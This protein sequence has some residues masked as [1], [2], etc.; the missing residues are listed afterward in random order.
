MVPG[1][2]DLPRGTSSWSNRTRQQ[3]Q[4]CLVSVR[5]MT[6]SSCVASIERNLLKQPG[7]S[8][9]NLDLFQS[10]SMVIPGCWFFRNSVGAGFPHGRQGRGQV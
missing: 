7:E 4:L 9:Q 5:G 6:C 3:G 8:Q 10:T 2:A 1:L